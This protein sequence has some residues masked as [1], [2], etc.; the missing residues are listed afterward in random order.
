MSIDT[1]KTFIPEYA[2]DLKLN[3]GSLANEDDL[4]DQ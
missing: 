3:L 2:K 4:N 1:L